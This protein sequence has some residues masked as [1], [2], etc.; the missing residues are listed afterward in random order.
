[1]KILNERQTK[2][3]ALKIVD[4]LTANC[5]LTKESA[6]Y[7]MFYN[8]MVGGMNVDDAIEAAGLTISQVNVINNLQLAGNELGN[9]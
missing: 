1:M 7:Q 8:I 6:G 4:E 5:G 3:N 2:N 9:H